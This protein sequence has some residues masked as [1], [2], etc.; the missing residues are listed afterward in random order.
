MFQ[1]NKINKMDLLST[2]LASFLVG[3]LAAIAS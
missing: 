1:M 2:F 3:F